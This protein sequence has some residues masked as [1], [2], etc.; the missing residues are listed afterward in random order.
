MLLSASARRQF[1]SLAC[2]FGSYSGSRDDCAEDPNGTGQMMMIMM[3]M[4]IISRG[5]TA[6]LSP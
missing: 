4:I 5:K 6:F 3:M 1:E 2:L